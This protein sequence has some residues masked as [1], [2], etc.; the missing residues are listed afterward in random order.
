M[1]HQATSSRR[2]NSLRRWFLSSRPVRYACAALCV[3]AISW[4]GFQGLVWSWARSCRIAQAERRWDDLEATAR[5]WSEW[6][7]RAADAWLY[8]A[9]AL[10]GQRRYI[11]AAEY[12]RKLPPESPKSIPALLARCQLLLGPANRPLDGEKACR[13]LLRR[14]PRATKAHSY[15][16]Q[17]YTLSLQREKLYEQVRE[18]IRWE[19]EPREAYI[20]YFL[21]DTIRLSN[22]EEMNTRWLAS[23]PGHELFTVARLLQMEDEPTADLDQS[24]PPA[25]P[26]LLSR[27]EQGAWTLLD[28]FPHNTNLLAYLI[29][30]EIARGRVEQV[31]E[32]LKRAP[33]D[34]EQDNRFWRFKGWVHYVRHEVEEA[35]RAYRRALELQPMDWT[36]INRLSE[37][38]RARQEID[39]AGRL[40]VLVRRAHLLRTKIG[41]LPHVEQTPNALLAELGALAR[42]CGDELIASALQKRVGPFNSERPEPEDPSDR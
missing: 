34:A 29:D 42:D 22:G 5:R 25:D 39:R 12:L 17:Y 8:L 27:K 30:Q 31:L 20:Y 4:A 23:H 33:R 21:I 32:L 15:L 38:L 37:V 11:E 24:R 28:R 36:S 9:D 1:S 13:E 40:Q 41:E 18:A 14:E 19:R 3:L 2:Q 6:Q 16:I 35:E 7:P 26:A 10:Q